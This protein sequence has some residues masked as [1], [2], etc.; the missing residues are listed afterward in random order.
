[1]AAW[2]DAAHRSILHFIYYRV[3][4]NY[5][6][7]SLWHFGYCQF[8]IAFALQFSYILSLPLP[9]T[10]HSTVKMSAHKFQEFLMQNK[11]ICRF[12]YL[13]Q[14]CVCMWFGRFD[15][16]MINNR[17]E[18]QQSTR[19]RRRERERKKSQTI[20]LWRTHTQT[21]ISDFWSHKCRTWFRLNVSTLLCFRGYASIF[22]LRFRGFCWANHFDQ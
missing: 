21:Q 22:F 7:Q 3:A 6:L 16:S 19:D 10:L 4:Y 8:E 1:M 2:L 14:K 13:L 20:T 17:Q 15:G 11:N 5:L 9:L 18:Q 12:F